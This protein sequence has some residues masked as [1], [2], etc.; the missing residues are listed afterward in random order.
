L[1]KSSQLTSDARNE[2]NA[3]S[4]QLYQVVSEKKAE[5]GNSIM[6]TSFVYDIPK[7]SQVN[8]AESHQVQVSISPDDLQSWDKE[9]AREKYEQVKTDKKQQAAEYPKEDLSDIVAEGLAKQNR[10]LEKKKRKD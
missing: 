9:K 7:N 8:S 5:I 6:A 10:Q 3:T 4:K 2:N 1:R